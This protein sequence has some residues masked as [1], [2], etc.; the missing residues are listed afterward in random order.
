MSKIPKLFVSVIIYPLYGVDLSIL[1]P[2]VNPAFCFISGKDVFIY[3]EILSAL[4]VNAPFE[5][6]VPDNVIL[7][8]GVPILILLVAFVNTVE[9]DPILIFPL[10]EL[11][12]K[13][14]FG[15][16]ELILDK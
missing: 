5:V 3:T 9:Y 1:P 6:I 15:V 13:F 16:V 11:I 7:S 12:V 8:D 2:I 4:V 14:P 10:P